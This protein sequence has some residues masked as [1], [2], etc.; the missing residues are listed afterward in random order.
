MEPQ[1][2]GAKHMRPSRIN[3]QVEEREFVAYRVGPSATA[4]LLL[5][6]RFFLESVENLRRKNEN[7]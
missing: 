7:P 6:S 4:R 1:V 3:V 5:R 2:F